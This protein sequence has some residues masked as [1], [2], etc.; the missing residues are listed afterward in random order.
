MISTLPNTDYKSF[1]VTDNPFTYI[2]FA[3]IGNL[4]FNLKGLIFVVVSSFQTESDIHY[5]SVR[6][7][8]YT[9]RKQTLKQHNPVLLQFQIDTDKLTLSLTYCNIVPSVHCHTD[10]PHGSCFEKSRASGNVVK[11]LRK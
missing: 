5:T 1:P 7:P 2:P 9:N 4:V 8:D 6:G 3:L 10:S 11:T